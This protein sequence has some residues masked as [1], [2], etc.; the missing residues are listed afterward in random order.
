MSKEDKVA[1]AK[2]NLTKDD[3]DG[4]EGCNRGCQESER[5][6]IIQSSKKI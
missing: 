4:A 6:K 3:N 5:R 1:P 2:R